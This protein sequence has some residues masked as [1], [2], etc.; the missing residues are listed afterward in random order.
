MSKQKF[1]PWFEATKEDQPVNIGV[2]EVVPVSTFGKAWFAYWN[3]RRFGYRTNTPVDAFAFRKASTGA[4]K[5]ARW[6][7]VLKE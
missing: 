2:Y 4:S 7:G 5:L 3:G 1:S 6:R